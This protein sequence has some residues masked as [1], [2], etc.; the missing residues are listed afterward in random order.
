[1]GQ[2]CYRDIDENKLSDGPL[3]SES[4]QTQMNKKPISS[5]DTTKKPAQTITEDSDL[6][7]E[8]DEF[9]NLSKDNTEQLDVV[10]NRKTTTEQNPQKIGI[11]SFRLLK[12]L[13]KGSFGKVMLVQHKANKKQYAMKVLL[14]KNIKNDRQKRHTQTERIILETASSDFLVKLRYAFQSPHKLYLVVD[15]MQGG[16]LFYHLRKIH[17]FKE[18]IARFYAAEILLGITYMHENNF[19]YRDLKP[20]NILLDSQ[21]HIKLTDFGLSKIVIDDDPLATSLCGTPEYLAPEILTTKTGYDKTCDWWSFGALLYEMLVGAPPFYSENKK[22]MIRKILTQQIPYPGF[23]SSKSKSLLQEL[24]VLDPKK[25]LGSQNDGFDIMEHEFFSDI[26][27]EDI[28]N[29]KIK[30]PYE[31]DQKDLKFFDQELTKQLAK[32]TPVNGTLV[33]QYQNFSNFTYVQKD[34]SV[35]Q[36]IPNK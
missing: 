27:F 2:V 21:G 17:R 7:L 24:L 5:D 30:P 15:Y 4:V 11:E 3:K 9:N 1:M 36:E 6:R 18:D 26:K 25:R 29:K 35:I 14:K 13:G 33:P 12:L 8:Q 23:L 19:I 10:E 32:D 34:M 31:F 22:E 28:V 16:E 20:E